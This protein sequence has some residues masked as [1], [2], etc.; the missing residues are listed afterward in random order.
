MTSVYL[1][2]VKSINFLSVKV[3]SRK[4]NVNIEPTRPPSIKP[5]LMER[6][7]GGYFIWHRKRIPIYFLNH[8][9]SLQVQAQVG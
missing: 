6:L 2:I 9:H 3:V 4:N 5:F 1:E 8:S 7:L